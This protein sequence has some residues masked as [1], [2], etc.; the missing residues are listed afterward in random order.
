VL[1]EKVEQGRWVGARV[2]DS[3]I[4]IVEEEEEHVTSN[5]SRVL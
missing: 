2:H 3:N 4:I 1:V 5:L